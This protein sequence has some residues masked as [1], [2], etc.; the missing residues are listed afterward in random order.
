M[1]M[2]GRTDD[3][4]KAAGRQVVRLRKPTSV[5]RSIKAKGRS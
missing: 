3:E 2:Q 5:Q 4:G 1:M